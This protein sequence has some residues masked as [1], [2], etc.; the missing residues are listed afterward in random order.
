MTL[1]IDELKKLRDDL[2]R[3]ND[4]CVLGKW[5]GSLNEVIDAALAALKAEADANEHLDY[6]VLAR[7][8]RDAAIAER[9]ALLESLRESRRCTAAHA[10]VLTTARA[11]AM[12]EAAR[13]VRKS[14]VATIDEMD[15]VEKE[16]RALAPLE[17]SLVAVPREVLE[18][19]KEALRHADLNTCRHESRHRGG[20]IWEI[21]DD[22]GQ[23]WADD[24]G[25]FKR[26]KGDD[27]Y[28]AALAALGAE[29][30][31]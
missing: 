8:E 28:A 21:C 15:S 3:T 11:L 13:W 20:A 2:S 9:D 29:V 30:K 25:G 1:G 6:C 16:I 4:L 18:Q 27:L 23:Q 12:E 26:D 31:P 14:I 7:G 5:R 24:R 17:V 22:C 19:V 10:V